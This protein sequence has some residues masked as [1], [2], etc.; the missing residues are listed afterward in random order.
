M[1]LRAVAA[2]VA[3]GLGRLCRS[4]LRRDIAAADPV[5]GARVASLNGTNPVEGVRVTNPVVGALLASPGLN[6]SSEDEFPVARV[7]A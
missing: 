2:S 7:L 4:I 5:V 6:G 1:L 3:R